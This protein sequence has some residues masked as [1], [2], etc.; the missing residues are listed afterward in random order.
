MSELKNDPSSWNIASG[1]SKLTAARP[2][3]DGVTRM[4]D[5]YR[6]GRITVPSSHVHN[7]NRYEWE[8]ASTRQA[9][10]DA[11]AGIDQAT[12]PARIC[13]R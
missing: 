3:E 13:G 1:L 6:F 4:R 7:V 12:S 5:R 10:E 11:K 2:P 9:A 8:G